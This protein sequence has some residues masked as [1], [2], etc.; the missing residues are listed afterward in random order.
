MITF[1]R[2][3]IIAYN[4]PILLLYIGPAVA[5]FYLLYMTNGN[6][7][8]EYMTIQSSRYT[9][10]YLT[11]DEKG[12]FRGMV[13]ENGNELFEVVELFGANF[14]LRKVF[15]RNATAP[16]GEVSTNS[17]MD[18]LP[19]N[20]T[21]SGSG[22]VGSTN[23]SGSGNFNYTDMEFEPLCDVLNSSNATFTNATNATDTAIPQQ[24]PEQQ[25]QQQIFCY[26]GFSI[27]DG[28]PGCYDT[29]NTTEVQLEVVAVQT[30]NSQ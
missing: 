22:C 28:R 29:P 15:F 14:A 25:P 13:P 16:R 5:Q 23:S 30:T 2:F 18:S 11:V 4:S 9:E 17:T 26:V 19:E 24:Q 21:L 7:R 1:S 6:N 10:W 12:K 8:R 3:I 20:T 27:E